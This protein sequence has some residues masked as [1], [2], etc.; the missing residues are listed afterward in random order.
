MKKP[1]VYDVARLAGVS[2]STVSRF[3]NQTGYIAKQKVQA[4]EQ[5]ISELS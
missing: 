2:V 4:I 3:N 5:A 1:T